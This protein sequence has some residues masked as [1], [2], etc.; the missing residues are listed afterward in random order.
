M[1]AILDINENGDIDCLYT[2]YI[3]LFAIGTV[4]NV[5]KAS[6]VEFNEKTQEWEVITLE[7]DVI[8][9][10]KNREKAIEF[11]I[12]VFSPGVKYCSI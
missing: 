4:V 1:K 2:D 11:E 6:N 3:N 5:R 9:K 12:E 8:H 10:N 7:G